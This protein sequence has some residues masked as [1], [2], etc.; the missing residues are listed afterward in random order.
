[1]NKIFLMFL[2]ACSLVWTAASACADPAT[3]PVMHLV[4]DLSDG[5]RIIGI[6]DI[7]GFKV[8][9][10]YA[11]LDVQFSQVRTVEFGANH[12]AQL[13]L[14]NGD[15]LNGKL[16]ITEIAVK[17]IFGQVT[18]SLANVRRMRVAGQGGAMPEGLVLHYTFN[19]D[20]GGKVTDTSG[21][22][23][24]GTVEGGVWSD[25]DRP[26]GAMK[27]SGD[28]QRIAIKNSASLQL[29]DFTILAWV[30]LA[31]TNNRVTMTG[32]S[33]GGMVFGYGQ[34]GYAMGF[35]GRGNLTLTKVGIDNVSLNSGINDNSFHQIGVTKKGSKIVF[36][37]DGAARQ[38]PD[39]STNFEFRTDVAVS[40][41]GD[42]MDS[43]FLGAVGEVEVF[44][45]A[46]TD[47]EVN[48]IYDSQK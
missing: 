7:D 48:G 8:T 1:M 37:V 14:Q 26:G 15:L 33:G 38:G 32:W 27:F 34:G 28:H 25:D 35:D 21:T 23:N 9:T 11:G 6:P 41:R 45:R 47:D 13:S 42:N 12:A 18:V 20:E 5:S 3:A 24:D 40:A 43:W 22:G 17:T 19:K 39:Y 16:A 44:N 46:L 4:L 31:G 30:K 10:Q 36:Y 29:Q 2:V